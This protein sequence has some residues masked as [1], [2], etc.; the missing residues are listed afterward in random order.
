MGKSVN[1][2]VG[3]SLMLGIEKNAWLVRVRF[4]EQ[5]YGDYHVPVDTIVYLTQ[6]MPV[7][8]RKLK[9]PLGSSAMFLSWEIIERSFIR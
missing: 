2:T 7:Y 1:G 6:L 4:S 5:H 3:G 8:G 9:T